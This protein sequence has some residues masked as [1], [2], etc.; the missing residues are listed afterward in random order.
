MFILYLTL[1]LAQSNGNDGSG[2]HCEKK[3]VLS[4]NYYGLKLGILFLFWWHCKY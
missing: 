2:I 4:I 3:S 1:L